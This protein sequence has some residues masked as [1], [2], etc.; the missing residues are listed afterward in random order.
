M[1]V[2]TGAKGF[3]W[4]A[5]IEGFRVIF[6]QPV[7]RL[8]MLWVIGTN[9]VFNPSS[10]FLAILATARSRGAPVPL[11][12]V[13]LAVAGAGGVIGAVAAP[14]V[15]KRAKPGP[16]LIA[17][18]WAGPIAAIGLATAPGAVLLGIIVACVFFRG[19]VVN[20]LI[21]AY[22]AE[23]VPDEMQ[24]RVL[25]AVMFISMIAMPI[26]VFLVGL[27]FTAAGPT[28]VFI[29]IGSVAA[30]AALPMLSRT[31]RTLPQPEDIAG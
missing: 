20:A 28:W 21:L 12:G 13:T 27:I 26:G 5:T 18:A 16:V 31:I 2:A 23:L 3:S 17:G 15:L 25:G 19:P 6:R 1:K 8:I 22:L 14:W 11:I 30:L 29:T 4:S 24:G 10:I 9:M 7:L